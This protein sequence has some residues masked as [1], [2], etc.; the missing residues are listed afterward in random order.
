[1][2]E[3]FY[4][5]WM[6]DE[7][8]EKIREILK[9]VKLNGLILDLG[10][11]PG[12]LSE[13]LKGVISLD[14]NKDY[15]LSFS[16]K[17]I[18]GDMNYLPFKDGVFDSVFSLDSFHFLKN[19]EKLKRVLKKGGKIVVSIFCNKEN[20]I[21]KGDKIEKEIKL[22][23]EDKFILEMNKEREIVLVFKK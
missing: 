7:Q 17:R 15:L 2:I 1:M 13:F 14:I 19:V 5:E 9:R 4:D 11:G 3:K 10:S 22:N 6:G 18:L 8:R 20:C 21:E 16:G 12:Y 23:L